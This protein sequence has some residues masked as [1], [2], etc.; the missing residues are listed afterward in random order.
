MCT[1]R[2]EAL[3]PLKRQHSIH[4]NSEEMPSATYI[5]GVS[6][7][8]EKWTHPSGWVAAPSAPHGA[9]W[10]LAYSMDG[11]LIGFTRPTTRRPDVSAALGLSENRVAFDL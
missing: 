3:T 1:E 10:V 8:I 7:Q 2:D 5:D 4:P 11:N 9:G 6:D